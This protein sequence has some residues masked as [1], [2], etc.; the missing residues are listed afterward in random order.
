MFAEEAVDMECF[1]NNTNVCPS[2]SS[3]ESDSGLGLLQ[4]LKCIFLIQYSV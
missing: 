3:S 2:S 4:H 1:D